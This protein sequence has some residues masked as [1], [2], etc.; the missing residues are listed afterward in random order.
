MPQTVDTQV[1]L[2]YVVGSSHSGSTLLALLADEHPQI[3]SVGETAVKPRIRREGRTASQVCS[4]GATLA[5]CAF[6]QQIFAAVSSRGV[7]FGLTRWSTEYRLETRWMH[8]L[9]TRETSNW[10]LRTAARW[11]MRHAPF[12]R[13]RT[14]RVDAANVAFVRAVLELT[15]RQVFF[16][17][18]KLL[19][20]LTHLLE[21][22]EF[23]VNVVHLVRDVRGVAASAKR[24]GESVVT[25]AQVWLNDQTAATRLLSEL[26][27]HRTMRVR[28]ED[29]CARPDEQLSRVWRFCGVEPVEVPTRV[30]AGAHHILGNNM[31]MHDE[32]Q[33]RVDDSWRSRLGADDERRVLAVAGGMN[34][35]MG[36]GR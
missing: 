4:C 12:L 16:D 7:P 2:T 27:S 36:Y 15:G 9:L 5:G 1:P 22:P 3:A 8:T 32:I 33:I 35:Q 31:R 11:A 14:S 13:A 17:T 29:L 26:P 21:V 30:R 10:M 19:T 25:A 34:E 28:Y 24:R 20:R 23:R 18:S 6:W